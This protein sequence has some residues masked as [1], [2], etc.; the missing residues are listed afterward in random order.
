MVN[1][2]TSRIEY[3]FKGEDTWLKKILKRFLFKQAPYVSSYYRAPNIRFKRS[4]SEQSEYNKCSSD[5]I[6]FAENYYYNFNI[7]GKL[8][9]IKLRDYQKDVL[10]SYVDGRTIV[11]NS[12]QMGVTTLNKIF[13]LWS[14]LFNPMYVQIVTEPMNMHY[15]MIDSLITSYIKIPYYLQKGIIRINN[16]EIVCDDYSRITSHRAQLKTKDIS[17]N[18]FVTIVDNAAW[19]HKPDLMDIERTLRHNGKV[20]ITSTPNGFNNFYNIWSNSL[21]KNTYKFNPIKLMWYQRDDFDDK[22][23]EHQIKNIGQNSFDKE[24]GLK[25]KNKFD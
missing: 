4:K 22:W 18:N 15:E 6:Y 24:Y 8:E 25:F 11:C 21:D 2:S 17:L 9:I 13:A 19:L 3:L 14:I 16:H 10:K 12:R 20:I 1:Y 7:E 23:A 5:I